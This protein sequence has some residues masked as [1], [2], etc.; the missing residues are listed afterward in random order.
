MTSREPLDELEKEVLSSFCAA[1]RPVLDIRNTMPKQYVEAF[2]LVAM[3]EG[4]S[5]TEYAERARSRRRPC[6][7]AYNT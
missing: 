1:L 2:L 7:S 3:E 6:Q 4:L 5:V